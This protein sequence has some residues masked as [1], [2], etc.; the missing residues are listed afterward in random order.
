MRF[1]TDMQFLED[2][3][4]SDEDGR[5][6]K[7]QRAHTNLE[8]A[9]TTGATPLDTSGSDSA[10]PTA[11]KSSISSARESA[12]NL[13]P[14]VANECDTVDYMKNI[15]ELVGEMKLARER[16]SSSETAPPGYVNKDTRQRGGR[17]KKS[18]K[19]SSEELHQAYDK[20]KA[21]GEVQ[22]PSKAVESM[23]DQTPSHF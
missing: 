8:D 4:Q 7:R 6:T 10:M 17:S 12:Q 13:R 1:A 14:S 9:N 16:I 22:M 23:V 3:R 21:D 19:L 5:P 2:D 20:H 11:T 15:T 18:K